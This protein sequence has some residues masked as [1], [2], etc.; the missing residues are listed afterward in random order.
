MHTVVPNDV[1]KEAPIWAKKEIEEVEE[2]SKDE[3][4]VE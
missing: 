4:M 1:I 2:E 3:K